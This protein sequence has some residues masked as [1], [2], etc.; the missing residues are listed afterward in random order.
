MTISKAQIAI[1]HVAKSKLAMDDDTYRNVLAKCAGVTRVEAVAAAVKIFGGALVMRNAAGF[2]TKGAVV[3]GAVGVGR[4]EA[5]VDN[6]AGIA[7]AL[8]VEYS[9]GPFLFANSAAGDLI[10][11]AGIAYLLKSM[12]PSG[13]P[14]KHLRGAAHAA[15]S[16]LE[17]AV[18]AQLGLKPGALAD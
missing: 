6:S 4:T 7:G 17:A 3:V 8:M 13:P 11:L 1:L 18:C 16:D 14:P 12:L 2:L 5:T 9:T 10:L 15:D